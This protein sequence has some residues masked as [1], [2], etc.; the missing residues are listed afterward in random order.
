LLEGLYGP[1][2]L[3]VKGD[4]SS[5][6]MPQAPSVTFGEKYLNPA[7]KPAPGQA[8]AYLRIHSIYREKAEPSELRPFVGNGEMLSSSLRAKLVDAARKFAISTGLFPKWKRR[9]VQM[10]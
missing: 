5:I 1:K 2:V 10:D 4:G 7:E 9:I 6:S 8:S 3:K